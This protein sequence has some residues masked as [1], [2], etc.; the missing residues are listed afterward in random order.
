MRT[1]LVFA[2]LASAAYAQAPRQQT[3]AQVFDGQVG[4]IEREILGLAQKMPAEKYNFAP[5]TGT[6]PAGTFDG[7]R[8]FALQVRHIAS[9]MYD[10]SSQIL[11]EKN[12]IDMGKALFGDL[13]KN[14]ELKLQAKL[15]ESEDA[16][17]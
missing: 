6:P 10:F 5:A 12:P 7:V 16:G 2:L 13:L 4:Q 15:T 17:G 1:L 3:L 14:V 9:V 8:T 11:G